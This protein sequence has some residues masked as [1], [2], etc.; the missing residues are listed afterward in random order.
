MTGY[1]RLIDVACAPGDYK[2]HAEHAQRITAV[3][4]G[5]GGGKI[6]KEELKRSS[7]RATT[8]IVHQNLIGGAVLQFQDRQQRIS[9]AIVVPFGSP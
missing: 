8:N 3:L 5:G 7:S 1:E 6:V 9:R 2:A 4:Y